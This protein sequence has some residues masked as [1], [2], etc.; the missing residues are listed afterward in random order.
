MGPRGLTAHSLTLL[1]GSKT[2]AAFQGLVHQSPTTVASI[3]TS[4]Q[5]QLWELTHRSKTPILTM[6][7]EPRWVMFSTLH[8][9]NPM[10]LA[11]PY[12]LWSWQPW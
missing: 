8:A 1:L 3:N 2:G 9:H 7:S 5:I 12:S 10:C 11:K 4:G 6:Q